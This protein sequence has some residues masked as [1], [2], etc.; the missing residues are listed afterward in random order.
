MEHSL[1]EPGWSAIV[2]RQS[3]EVPTDQ[4]AI[5]APIEAIATS[6]E[7]CTTPVEMVQNV[8]AMAF[9]PVAVVRADQLLERPIKTASVCRGHEAEPL[10]TIAEHLS[11]LPVAQETAVVE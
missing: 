10:E 3:L 4:G 1:E 5:R 11:L 6:A 7:S 2:A 8:V 9:E